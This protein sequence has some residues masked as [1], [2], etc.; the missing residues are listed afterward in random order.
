[1]T[2]QELRYL[3]AIAEHRHFGRAA[4]SCHVT[5]PTLSA[6][7]RKLEDYLGLPLID[8]SG[9]QPVPTPAGEQIVERA[10]RLLAEADAILQLT[11]QRIGPLQ[12]AL[13]IGLIPTLA[14][15]LLPWLLGIVRAD[16]PRLHLVVHED[17]TRHLADKL[18]EQMLDVAFLALPMDFGQ[19]AR[20]E[21][22]L[23][24]EPFFVACPAGHE[25]SIFRQ[26]PAHALADLKLMLL[27]DGHC[28]RGQALAACGQ[29]D[30][31]QPDAADFRA[32]SLETLIQ[33]V[34]CGM[35]CTLLPALAVRHQNRTDLVVRP[36]AT[37]ES[38]RIGM[39]WRRGHPRHADLELLGARLRK[40]VPEG[41]LALS[42]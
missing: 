5:Q 39:V 38:R 7:L 31:Q 21:Y 37:A 40:S 15:Y 36:L 23:F 1:M 4:E 17:M 41:T 32:T 35:G 16:Y 8:R 26:V 11:R 13:N 14:P 2:L 10:R 33:L 25:I 3:V 24:S 9:K 34:A 18:D 20:V 19:V 29:S 30:A 42:D 6:Q 12:G 22:A 27:T 28:L